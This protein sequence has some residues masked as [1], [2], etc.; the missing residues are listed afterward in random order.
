MAR[1]GLVSRSW[2]AIRTFSPPG[3]RLAARKVTCPARCPGAT[4]SGFPASAGSGRVSP[5]ADGAGFP[6]TVTGSRPSSPGVGPGLRRGTRRC[7]AARPAL[8]AAPPSPGSRLP[9]PRPRRMGA[10]VRTSARR[11]WSCS[12]TDALVSPSDRP[13]LGC[14]FAGTACSLCSPCGLGGCVD[15]TR[16]LRRG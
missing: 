10:Q 9:A 8:P 2:T 4:F 5:S 1:T 15:H 16:V 6:P 11:P 3:V 13:R 14:V 7:W 12:S